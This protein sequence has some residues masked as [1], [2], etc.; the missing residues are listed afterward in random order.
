MI[1]L[2]GLPRTA[3]GKVDRKALPEPSGADARRTTEFVAP[4]TPV[5]QELAGMWADV[6]NVESVGIHDDFFALG[7]HSLL[8][9]QL[10]SRVRKAFPVELPL[11]RLFE[12]PTVA[13][14]ASL[15]AESLVEAESDEAMEAMLTEIEGLS[16][17]EVKDI[18][19]AESRRDSIDT[20]V[21]RPE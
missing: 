9:T 18:L 11:R 13:G 2:P 15:I 3:S 5:E 19:T 17:D 12:A 10:I 6:L 4:R 1:V 16:D 7:G 8:G 20:R 14:L 21:E